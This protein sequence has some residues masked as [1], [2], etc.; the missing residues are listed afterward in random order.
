MT[1]S[2]VERTGAAKAHRPALVASENRPALPRSRAVRFT[3]LRLTAPVLFGAMVYAMLRYIVFGDVS[4]SQLPLYI[5]NKAISLAALVLLCAASLARTHRDRKT[6]GLTA[7]A[8]AGV[9]VLASFAMLT[10]A[11]Y[12]KLFV[13]SGRLSW[14]G[15][16]SMLAG[17]AACVPLVWLLWATPQGPV[18]E[19]TRGRSLIPGLGR[20]ALVGTAVHVAAMGLPGWLDVASWPGA[21]PPITLLSFVIAAA[22]TIAKMALVR[23]S[24]EPT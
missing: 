6:L 16:L 19:P 1:R 22:A 12:G 21:L 15:E 18:P 23:R 14:P 3:P 17:A 4:A 7:I 2:S 8:L 9:H 5:A 10:P 13:G 20:I 11:Y 24:R